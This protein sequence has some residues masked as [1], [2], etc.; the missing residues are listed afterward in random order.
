MKEDITEKYDLRV[1]RYTSYPTSPHFNDSV[2]G[3]TYRRWLGELDTDTPLSLYFH[4]PFCD[5]MCWFCGCY[6]KIVK[7]YE[8]VR[9]Y[10]DVLLKEIDVVADALSG[11][12]K[13]RHIHWG[14]GS[15]TMLKGEDWRHTIDKLRTRFDVVENAEIAVELDPRTA[16]EDY[17]KA[18]AA[19][20]V[21]RTSIGVQGFHP[22]VQKAINRVQPF[23]LTETVV[24]WL[25]KHGIGDINMDLLYGLPHQTVERV[26]KQ[27]EMA[28]SLKPVR[29]ALFGYAHVPWM[30]SNQKMIDEDA[31]P[32]TTER[33]RQFVASSEKLEELGYL[34]VG[35]DH[36]ALPSDELA[37]ALKEGRLH[38][39]FQG[40]TTDEAPVMLGL[41]AS[42]I[43]L[44]PQGYAQNAAPLK[45]YQDAVD[46]GQLP[47]VRGIELSGEDRLRGEIIERLMCDFSID[48]DA[49][50]AQHTGAKTRAFT[51]ELEKLAALADDGIVVLDGARITITEKGRPFVRLVAAVFDSY[52][53]IGEKRHSKAV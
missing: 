36:F 20:G 47:I 18:M 28:A 8:P 23:E 10:L 17:V 31:L 53:N 37:V 49:V 13:T 6:T 30:K 50:L 29:V 42:G 48:L 2:D 41:G 43:G 39:N 40:Y 19:A 4:I 16:T 22:D 51:E 46:A 3:E 9:E 32:D 1:P 5:T 12:F 14:G 44:L 38:R 52:L 27:A 11:R 26:Q 21:N 35:L 15:P 33:W 45:D 24:G 25:R 34:A 7:R